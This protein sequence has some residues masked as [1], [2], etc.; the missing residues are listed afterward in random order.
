MFG[1]TF[2]KDK[3]YLLLSINKN[4][5]YYCAV[6]SKNSKYSKNE[7]ITSVNT[8][9]IFYN[10]KDYVNSILET[11]SKN[12]WKDCLYYNENKKRWRSIKYILM[13]D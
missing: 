7:T 12:E 6:Y 2:I 9:E 1:K 8:G 5:I 10:L 3:K 4:D 11:K 13:K